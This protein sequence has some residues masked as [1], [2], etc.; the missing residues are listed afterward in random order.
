[1]LLSRSFSVQKLKDNVRAVSKKLTPANFRSRLNGLCPAVKN[2]HQHFA[3][4]VSG[5]A[6]S[7]S[8]LM[9]GAKA[10]TS[11]LS[12][13]VLTFD[14]GL[15]EGS[16]RDANFVM[17]IA[18]QYN[19]PAYK[20]KMKTEKPKNSIQSWARAARYD[21]ML[22]WCAKNKAAGLVVAHH[23]EDQAETFLQR[24]AR[25]SSVDG[26]CAMQAVSAHENGVIFRPFLDVARQTLHLSLKGEDVT[27]VKDP[28]NKDP[29]YQRVLFRQ[30][31][32]KLA[33]LG[34]TPQKIADTAHRLQK[35]REV[36]EKL[37]RE[38]FE[39]LV[40]CDA[41]GVMSL[42][43]ESFNA[44]AEDI[45]MRLLRHLLG[46]FRAY[47]PRQAS[48]DKLYAIMRTGKTSRQT[49]AGQ[50]V[51]VKKTSVSFYREPSDIDQIP[52]I[53]PKGRSHI[54]DARFLIHVSKKMRGRYEVAALGE[55]GAQWM[56]DKGFEIPKMPAHV[57]H[58][59]ACIWRMP[60]EG[61]AKKRG[62]PL[63]IAG[64]LTHPDINIDL[65]R[66]NFKK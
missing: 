28:S 24:L 65:W 61:Q 66:A 19:L 56:R 12:F 13:S 50:I 31:S 36:L 57:L 44:L 39:K 41:F 54:W 18:K 46:T 62:E 48:I 23:L 40:Q 34:L 43:R 9:L 58:G 6:D 27:P 30:N 17:A 16:A 37:A 4:A 5:G 60:D 59:L 64:I 53:L 8:L 15:R 49:L 11:N 29:R 32:H 55:K 38:S 3:L 2:T 47:P 22:T 25:G 14:H 33:E 20:L 7:L 45:G 1:M 26:L 21:A 35:S 10:Q 51:S 63:A 42:G 52:F